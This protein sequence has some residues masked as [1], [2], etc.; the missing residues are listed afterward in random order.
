MIIKSSDRAFTAAQPYVS[1]VPSRT[2]PSQDF[3]LTVK[4]ASSHPG[5]DGGEVEATTE[6]F[7]LKPYSHEQGSKGNKRLSLRSITEMFASKKNSFS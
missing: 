7:L 5:P 3:R 2:D 4:T 6:H 1:L